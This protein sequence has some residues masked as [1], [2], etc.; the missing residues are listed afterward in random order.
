MADL[1]QKPGQGDGRFRAF[2]ARLISPSTK[3]DGPITPAPPPKV[4]K[5]D[6]QQP[7]AARRSAPAP[8]PTQ[9]PAPYFP[10]PPKG[11]TFRVE[12]DYSVPP[13]PPGPP[14]K[15][16]SGGGSG[17]G[18]NNSPDNSSRKETTMATA[19]QDA[20]TAEDPRAK[21]V[22][23][24]SI[25]TVIALMIAYIAFAYRQHMSNDFDNT[26]AG[27]R[28]I[29]IAE[30]KADVKKI[31]AETEQILAK[32]G[33]VPAPAPTV[34]ATPSATIQAAPV[35]STAT[36]STAQTIPLV[37]CGGEI[38][39]FQVGPND[40]ITTSGNGCFAMKLVGP[41]TFNGG[42]L[43][44]MMREGDEMNRTGDVFGNTMSHNQAWLNDQVGRV[45]IIAVGLI[46]QTETTPGEVRFNQP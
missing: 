24:A 11:R 17:N 10:P 27:Q 14:R 28:L 45:V 38:K 18:S 31:E 6:V 22:V 41:V 1:K 19:T 32:N 25:V 13:R 20:A 2:M 37:P 21:K 4:R 29:G 30:K 44:N 15:D 39:W 35:L 33:G 9:P 34:A 12:P 5:E 36:P 40:R 43:F 26:P 16:G 7:V 23:I 3:E 8:A 42:S 46:S